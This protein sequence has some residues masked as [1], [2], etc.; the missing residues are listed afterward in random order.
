MEFRFTLAIYF[1]SMLLVGLRRRLQGLDDPIGGKGKGS[2][3]LC[4][5]RKGKG[6]ERDQNNRIVPRMKHLRLNH[7]I[8]KCWIRIGYVL[9]LV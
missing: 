5:V 3:K 4:N 2:S 7:C 8:F 1:L 6:R 9:D